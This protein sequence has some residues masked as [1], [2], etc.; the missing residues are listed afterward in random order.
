VCH[1]AGIIFATFVGVLATTLSLASI[2]LVAVASGA[3]TTAAAGRQLFASSPMS[4]IQHSCPL[5]LLNKFIKG[6]TSALVC[7]PD[8][9]MTLNNVTMSYTLCIR[10][11]LHC[12]MLCNTA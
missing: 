7:L 5:F 4:L 2:G 12:M 8:D 6:M 3:G 10:L 1:A 9:A 11:L